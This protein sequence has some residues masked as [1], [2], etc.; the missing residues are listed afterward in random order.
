MHRVSP[1]GAGHP[2]THFEALQVFSKRYDRARGR[3]AQRHRLI[4]AIEGGLGGVDQPFPA[5]LLD[6]LF[7]EIRTGTGLA[8]QTLF[9]ELDNHAL[10]SRG[11]QAGLH[12]D[13]G[14]PLMRDR[15]GHVFHDGFPGFHVLK[16]L[17]HFDRLNTNIVVSSQDADRVYPK[18]SR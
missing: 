8:H 3:I 13:K 4:E 15:H 9:G 5:R 10:G 11:D 7:D 16:K 18:K 1:T 2:L 17:F 14:L 6:D 12:F